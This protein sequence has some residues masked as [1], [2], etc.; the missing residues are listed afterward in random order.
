MCQSVHGPSIDASWVPEGN[1]GFLPLEMYVVNL[2][3]SIK[4][5]IISTCSYANAEPSALVA[6]FIF[7]LLSTLAAAGD[8]AA[9]AAAAAAA[10]AASIDTPG[11][12]QMGAPYLN[13]DCP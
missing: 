10:A 5:V 8:R 4:H 3:P 11:T 9:V 12:S 13:L 2:T 1:L 7:L 6:I